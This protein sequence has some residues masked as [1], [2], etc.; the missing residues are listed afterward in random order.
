MH[1][2]FLW[3]LIVMDNSCR[4]K[5]KQLNKEKKLGDT[6]KNMTKRPAEW[7]MKLLQMRSNQAILQKM[8]FETQNLRQLE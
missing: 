5:R 8:K 7:K 4:L 1:S 2:L 3:K 6:D